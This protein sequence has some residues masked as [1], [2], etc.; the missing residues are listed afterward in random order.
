MSGSTPVPP[1][2]VLEIGFT[3]REW[4]ADHEVMVNPM[5]DLAST[6]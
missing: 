1:Q 6:G 4:H 3:A 5:A 2:F